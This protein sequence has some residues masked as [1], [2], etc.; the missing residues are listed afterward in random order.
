ARW[1]R[2]E[3]GDARAVVL[4]AHGCHPARARRHRLVRRPAETGS[5]RHPVKVGWPATAA[6]NCDTA[7]GV[8]TGAAAAAAAA[9]VVV[10]VDARVVEVLVVVV[11]AVAHDTVGSAVDSV[12]AARG[13][14]FDMAPGTACSVARALGFSGDSVWKSK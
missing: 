6:A 2:G 11:D 12:T 9:T 4:G 7:A 3:S 13:N 5:G 10:V 8:A 1:R 14:G